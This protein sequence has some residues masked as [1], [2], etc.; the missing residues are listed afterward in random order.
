LKP[1]RLVLP[2]ALFGAA[3]LGPIGASP[4]GAAGPL[5]SNTWSTGTPMPTARMW[6]ASASAGTRTYGIGGCNN[7]SC[8]TVYNVN[9][10]YTPSTGLWA[11]RNPMP[12]ARGILAAAAAKNSAGV[13]QIYALGG[14][15]GGAVAN[16]EAYNAPAN[17]W[18]EEAPLPTGRYA[19][20][21]ATGSNNLIYTFGGTTS[22]SPAPLLSTVEAYNPA[23]NT[24]TCS[25]GDTNSGCTASTIAPIP[26]GSYAGAAVAVGN[27]IYLIIGSSNGLTG[28]MYAYNVASNVWSKQP[29]MTTPRD[30][31]GVA[32]GKE[33]GT[34]PLGIYAVGGL[35][36]AGVASSANEVYTPTTRTWSTEAPLP[37]PELGPGVATLSNGNI[38]V[39]GG[40]NDTMFDGTNLNQIYIP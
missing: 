35:N 4:A 9:E 32:K 2:L 21:A 25:V 34:G 15:N 24:W 3:L 33:N 7:D 30:F 14:F 12:V 1:T 10:A 19:L 8:S 40:G 37:T 20:A 23:T 5:I 6:L 16:N 18:T 29:S 26:E 39:A 31:L 27:L 11:A 22:A 36:S 28:D 13:Q 17:S 38:Q